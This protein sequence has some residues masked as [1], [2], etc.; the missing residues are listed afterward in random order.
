MAFK[1]TNFPLKQSVI[2][3]QFILLIAIIYSWGENQKKIVE[4]ILWLN[5]LCIY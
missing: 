3:L 2:I 1:F 5:L 4:T